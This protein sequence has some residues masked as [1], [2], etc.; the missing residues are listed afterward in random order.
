M[1]FAKD[2]FHLPCRR[3][4]WALLHDIPSPA[5]EVQLAPLMIRTF[6]LGGGLEQS[7]MF[8]K[9]ESGHTEW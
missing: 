1:I 5:V 4:N 2:R 7:H 3:A 8:C 9:E 6:H